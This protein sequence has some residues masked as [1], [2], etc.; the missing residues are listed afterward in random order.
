MALFPLF[1]NIEGKNV[2]IVGAGEVAL[3]KIEKLLPFKPKITV[4]AKEIKRDEIKKLA[5][6][7][8]INLINRGFLFT[9]IDRKELVIVAVDDIN[10]QRE[11]YN[12]CVRKKI[13]VN[14]VDSP[15]YC[16][17]IFPAYVKKDDI[18]IGITTSGNLPGLSAKLRKH[19]E[20][21]IPENLEDIFQKIKNVRE[22][23]PKGK[24]RQKKILQLIDELFEEE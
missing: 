18:V 1:I 2:L 10:L 21:N 8:K 20:K 5:E 12:Y 16:T 3:R 17:F 22:E 11:I 13:P 15:D 14:S 7:G 19:I 23:L 24:D 4:V 6:E 9:D